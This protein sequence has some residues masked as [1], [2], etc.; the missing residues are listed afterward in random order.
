M[1]VLNSSV[2]TLNVLFDQLKE[3]NESVLPMIYYP[4][5]YCFATKITVPVYHLTFDSITRLGD[6]HT[7]GIQVNIFK[8]YYILDP[9]FNLNQY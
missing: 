4:S 6:K 2:W 9:W 8:A 3:S 7:I 5:I 1:F